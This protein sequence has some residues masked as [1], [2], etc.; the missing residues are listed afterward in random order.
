MRARLATTLVMIAV[1]DRELARRLDQLD[2]P[3][4]ARV[5]IDA[6][7]IRLAAIE[8]PAWLAPAA[9]ARTAAAINDAFVAG[10]RSVA[11]VAAGLAAASAALGLAV[12]SRSA[13]RL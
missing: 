13:P 6:Q 7:R 4:A 3:R 12:P 9:R 8:I 2:L 10:F 11:L 1:F 5:A